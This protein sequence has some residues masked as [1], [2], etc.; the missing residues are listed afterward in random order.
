MDYSNLLELESMELSKTSNA[1]PDQTK[2]GGNPDKGSDNEV[3]IA[4]NNMLFQ[5]N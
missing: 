5:Y 4:L 2:E 3:R 1:V